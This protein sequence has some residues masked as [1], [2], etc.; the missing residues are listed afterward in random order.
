MRRKFNQ[1][2]SVITLEK[3]LKSLEESKRVIS[4]IDRQNKPKKV[5]KLK[6]I[7]F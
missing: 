4:G 3:A 2:R 7:Y 6:E 5:F 1:N